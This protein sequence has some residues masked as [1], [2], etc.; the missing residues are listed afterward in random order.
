[1][2]SKS[3]RSLNS[4]ERGSVAVVFGL[5]LLALTI[6]IGVAVDYSRATAYYERTQSALDSVVLAVAKAASN[7]AKDAEVKKIG[8]T[9][10]NQAMKGTDGIKFGPLDIQVDAESGE[11]SA[12]VSGKVRTIMGKMIGIETINRELVSEAASSS[13][14]IELG[15][16]L[17]VS[18]S[19]K[20]GKIAALKEAAGDL[21]DTLNSSGGSSRKARIAI[22]PYS[23]SVNLGK[24]AASAKGNTKKGTC[25]SE[26]KG[27]NAFTDSNPKAGAMGNKASD[28]PDPTIQPLSDDPDAVKSAINALEADGSTAGHLG[29]AWAWYLVSEKWRDFWPAENAPEEKGPETLKAVVLMTDGEFNTEYESD[30]GKSA[31]QAEK[32]CA[33]MKADGLMIFT[34]AFDAPNE[35]LPL[36]AKCATVPG[37]AFD[38]K[39]E[40]GLKKSFARIA[41][42][43]NDLRIA[44]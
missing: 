19:M 17:D 7:G 31:V 38:A 26:R 42:Y 9:Y 28:C 16:M 4:D 32:L 2:V 25:V 3:N 37:Y 10:F 22:A 6:A 23:T 1:M 14:N 40:A 20:G 44:R 21:V 8:Q 30:N 24:Y 43:L 41:T 15:M 29:I 35:V 27:A 18:G 5:S 34:V 33:N 13:K 11:V 12:G 39:D 36:F